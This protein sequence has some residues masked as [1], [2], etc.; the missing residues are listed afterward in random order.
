[1]S[2]SFADRVVL[3]QTLRPAFD[4][5]LIGEHRQA[6]FGPHSPALAALLLFLRRNPD[7]ALPR[8]CIIRSGKPPRWG[9]GHKPSRPGLSITA[10]TE[11]VYR[12]RGEAEHAVFLRRLIDYGLLPGPQP[13]A[14]LHA[15]PVTEPPGVMG[16]LSQLSAAPGT[17]LA[18]HVSC[19]A[20]R[21][22]AELVR[23]YSADLAPEGASLREVP[24][25]QVEPFERDSIPQRTAVGSFVR[26]DP[27]AQLPDL[28]QGL[29]LSLCVMPSLPADGMQ[30][31]ISH[32]GPS[33]DSG[34][35]L[36]L[37]ENGVPSLWVGS[38]AGSAA[39]SL[40]T[41]LVRGCWYRLVAVIDSQ[42]RVLRIASTPVGTRA[43]NRVW[44]GRGATEEA[45]AGLNFT[46]QSVGNG[47]LLL[48]AAFLDDL[49]QPQEAFDGRIER[50]TL[51]KGAIDPARS[52]TTAALESSQPW[53]IWDFSAAITP[54]GIRHPAVVEDVGPFGWHG[55]CVNH[56]TRAVRSHA[57]TGLE[58]DF[59][60]APQ[61]Y[62]AAHFHRDD[63]TDCGWTPQ[64]RFTPPHGL[65]SGVYAVRL[66]SVGSTNPL[67][68][69][70]PFI[71]TP[72]P[73][74][75]SAR[76]LLVLPTNSYLAY[77]NDH[78]GVD[79]PRMENL[80]RRALQFDEFDLYR[81]H[82]REL[83]S[84][85]YESHRDGTGICY[86]SARRPI[87]T[88]RP[89]VVTYNG[90]AWQF[91]ADMQLVDWLDR[92]GH[93]VDIVSDLDVH[94]GGVELLNR[95]ACVMTGTHPE[96]PTRQM[97]DAYG[98][99]VDTGGRLIYMGG[100]G[101][102]WVTAYDPDDDQVIEIRRWG[103]SE[104]WRAPPGE[105]HLSF[106]GEP[107]G[108]WRDSG[109]AP[110]KTVGVGFV[111]SGLSFGGARYGPT[112]ASDSGAAWIL[113]G[114]PPGEFGWHGTVGPAAGLEVDAV[115]AELGTPASAIVIASSGGRHPDEMLEA[116]ENYGMT[117]AAPGG[118]G[119]VRVRSDMVLVP[120]AGRGGV[121]STGSIAWAGA[122]AHD[123]SVS[124]ILKNVLERFCSDRPLLD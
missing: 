63:M 95:Y 23:L 115:D 70:V 66:R 82:H 110:Q 67:E 31:L 17:E 78:V 97:L 68:D 7:P 86:S 21:W 51:L 81:H 105:H 84:S 100:N 6:P 14:P 34:W 24:V 25:P 39:V 20:S 2:L 46:P 89:Q 117:L 76:L 48:A 53:A 42:A 26:I 69:W 5:A 98:E 61:E 119:N 74:K 101:F 35:S 124:R 13:A 37:S 1:M 93:A 102:Y 45:A 107:G 112:L 19:T 18:L 92:N 118:R 55:R 91:T 9:I 10:L 99:Y 47:P 108:L 106:T 60:H 29:S 4:P 71:V 49:G 43:S 15:A 36:R 113:D 40:R 22:R 96:Y 79:S 58:P 94:Q 50:P 41:P 109:R 123:A 27:P 114:V 33:T 62:A 64:A 75:S 83:G 56:P 85:L 11:L 28:Q 65:P 88:M 52:L 87:M 90:R 57:W 121:F 111:A 16:Y 122:L 38:L 77:A 8:Y 32:R 54:A 72:P 116:R 3:D 59:R 104:A 12:S 80:T 44:I 30:A 103:G 120:T 73:G